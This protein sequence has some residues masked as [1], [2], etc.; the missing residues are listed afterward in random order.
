MCKPTITHLRRYTNLPSAIDVLLHKRLTLL[1]P[2]RWDDKNDASFLAAYKQQVG[3]KALLALCFTKS[4]ET[5]HHWRTYSHGPDG[6]CFEFEDEKLIANVKKQDGIKVGDA[7]YREISALE[8]Q[9]PTIEELPFVKRYPYMGE[10]EFRMLYVNS[11]KAVMAKH[12]KI[13]LSW[14]RRVTLSPWMPTPLVKTVI[15]ALKS[16]ADN[17]DIEIYQSK[18]IDYPRWRNAINRDRQTGQR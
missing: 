9:L 6:V 10:N 12:L 15:T 5:Y 3:A 16:V 14:I 7:I 2:S 18:L 17:Q 1:D 4:S 11:K 13:D 8:Q